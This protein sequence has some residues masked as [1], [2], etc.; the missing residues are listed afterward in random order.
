MCR[1]RTAFLILIS[2]F[3]FTECSPVWQLEKVKT[4]NDTVFMPDAV[5]GK[6]FSTLLYKADIELLGSFYSGLL[7]VKYDSLQNAHFIVA[8]S[9]FGLS[10]LDMTFTKG[11]IEINNI[12]PFLDRRAVKKNLKNSFRI[13][14]TDLATFS[15]T[16][17]YQDAERG[18]NVFKIKDKSGRY[19]Y[20]CNEQNKTD[21][22]IRRLWGRNRQTI[23]INYNSKQYPQ[24][25]V[26]VNEGI[27]FSME[28][29]LLKAN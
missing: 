17:L 21:K 14:L 1:L 8:M 10:F 24:S 18:I 7:F 26:L 12:Q 4:N 19:Y 28:L 5:I 2:I 22:I 29:N 27:N 11:E 20:F 16:R 25:I 15:N 13:L 23:S 9:E 3:V 6:D